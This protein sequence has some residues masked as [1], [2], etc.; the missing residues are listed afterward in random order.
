MPEE[1]AQI[2][3]EVRPERGSSPED[4]IEKYRKLAEWRQVQD[5]LETQGQKT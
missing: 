4:L 3:L 2:E 1:A 5:E